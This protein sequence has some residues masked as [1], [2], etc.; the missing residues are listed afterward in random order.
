V[1]YASMLRCWH[2]VWILVRTDHPCLG[3]GCHKLVVASMR[4]GEDEGLARDEGGGRRPTKHGT[5]ALQG[6]AHHRDNMRIERRLRG[7]HKL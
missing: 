3:V 2:L 7:L 6:V 1:Y 5:S 4:H